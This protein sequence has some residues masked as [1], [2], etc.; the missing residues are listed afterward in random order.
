MCNQLQVPALLS[1]WNEPP[2]TD[3]IGGWL[4]RNGGLDTARTKQISATL[5]NR[6]QIRTHINSSA[7]LAYECV[8]CLPDVNMYE[9]TKWNLKKSDCYKWSSYV[10]SVLP[11]HV[12]WS[13]KCREL[14]KLS[15]ES[16][17]IA[18]SRTFWTSWKAQTSWLQSSWFDS[19]IAV[20][21]KWQRRRVGGGKSYMETVLG[22]VD[23]KGE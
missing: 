9:P 22:V 18:D 13:I 2:I 12:Q 17:V 8:S 23:R 16:A 5:G 21:K 4:G 15:S 6:D 1:V 14:A 19:R 3:W 7:V 20:K 10:M 11:A